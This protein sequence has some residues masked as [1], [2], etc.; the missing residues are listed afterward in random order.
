MTNTLI[1]IEGFALLCGT[2][3]RSPASRAEV[4]ASAGL[5]EPTFSA[6]LRRWLPLLATGE[7]AHLALCF[8]RAYARARLIAPVEGA[9]EDRTVELAAGQVSAALPFRPAGAARRAP[10]GNADATL[11]LQAVPNRTQPLPFAPPNHRLQMFDTQ[12]GAPLAVPV[13]AKEPAPKR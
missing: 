4:L 11:E 12:T 9:D 7:D 13:W 6:L 2:I 8:A 5:D 1:S 3:D 10:G